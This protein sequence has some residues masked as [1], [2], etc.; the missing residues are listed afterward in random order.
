[1][2]YLFLGLEL[3]E[4][5]F[6]LRVRDRTLKLEPRALDVLLYLVRNR[7]RV[8]PK[9]ELLEKVWGVRFVS[10]S[11]LFH[12]VK[13]ARQAIEEAT[14]EEAIRTVHGRGFRFV[15]PIVPAWE[16][17]GTEPRTVPGTPPPVVSPTPRRRL[18]PVVALAAAAAGLLVLVQAGGRRSGGPSPAA[19]PSAPRRPAAAGAHP[20]QLT[21]GLSTAVKPAFSPDGKVLLYVSYEP[22]SPD[23]LDVYVMPSQGGTSWRLTEG[24]HA[25]GDLPVFT[26]DSREIVF[27]RFRTGADG[28]HL[29]DLWR[30]GS[31]GG[32]PS[33]WVEGATGAGFS[34]DGRLVAYTKLVAGRAVLVVGPAQRPAEAAEVAAPGFVPRFSPDGSWLAYTTSDPNGGAGHLFARSLASGELRRLTVDAMQMYGLAWLPDGATLVFSGTSGGRFV[35][36]SVGLS[37]PRPEPMTLGVGDFSSPAV[38]ADGST[39]AFA[40]G[41]DLANLELCEGLGDAAE[42][43]LTDDEYHRWPRLSPD[44]RRVASVVQRAEVLDELV[45]TDLATR[46]RTLLARGRPK[47]PCWAGEGSVA[48]LEKETGGA[49]RVV[50]VDVSTLATAVVSRFDFGAEWLAV[51][52]SGRRLAVGRPGERN[53]SALVVRDLDAG[54]DEVVAGGAAFEGIRFGPDGTTLSWSGPRRSGTPATNGIWLLRKGGRAPVRLAPDGYGPLFAADGASVLFARLDE[55]GGLYR[56]PVAG[57]DAVPL[58]RFGRGVSDFDQVLDRLVWV[59]ESGRNQVYAV[60]LD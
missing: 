18:V 38:S 44:G 23:R 29:P 59:Q 1:M 6:E 20:R 56:V 24:I 9:E 17:A 27:T 49:T 19:V 53:P 28:T 39:L 4:E 58:R 2:L 25:S 52:P 55:L 13:K 43:R 8:V 46:R 14:P 3:D 10:E 41:N 15:A 50:S 5:K 30:V 7:D 16:S 45:L 47:F 60:P 42:R 40:H 36:W 26:A 22:E 21:S 34:P 48:Y 31:M 54:V 32:P 12:A 57:G 51:A 33:L 11:A 35:L 37:S